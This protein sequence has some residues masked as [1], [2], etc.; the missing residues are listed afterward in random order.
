MIMEQVV[1]KAR[2]KIN[3]TLDVLDKREDGYHD[4]EMIMQTVNLYDTVSIRKTFKDEIKLI[5]N[6]KW[7]PSDDKNLAYKAADII[8]QRYDIKTGVF[9]ELRKKIPVAAGLA[10][11]SSDAAA[12][13]VGMRTLFKL[14]ITT[15]ELMAIGK[16]LG[17]DVPYCIMR[18]TALAQGIGDIL[19]RLPSCPECHVVLAKP[20][21]SVSTPYIYKMIDN[22][23]IEVR[24][25]TELVIQ[26]IKDRDIHTI[27]K[28][29]YNVMEKVTANE[30]PIIEQLKNILIERGAL[31]A[32]M[33]GSGPTV[34]G[35][36]DDEDKA[37]DAYYRLKVDSKAKD[38]FIT[39]TY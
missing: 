20:A 4:I 31:G 14:N 35:L 33:S 15:S 30:H 16:E 23:V 19:T 2:A 37:K 6:L 26:A 38:V 10:G 32:V 28:N 17:A 8:K 24:P 21:V 36:F 34:F 11:G 1:L 7:L 27:A 13:L 9:I 29:M 22:N 5:T 18:K 39:T 12:V 3:L 25:N